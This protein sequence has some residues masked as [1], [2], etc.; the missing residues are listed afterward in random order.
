[1]IDYDKIAQAMYKAYADSLQSISLKWGL[2]RLVQKAA[3]IAAAKAA[4]KEPTLFWDEDEPERCHGSV[5]DV[6][7]TT[8]DNRC[9]EVGDEMIIEMAVRLPSLKV[10]ITATEDENGNTDLEWEEV[11]AAHQELKEVK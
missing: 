5:A 1:M 2:L 9:L 3:W 8:H 6:I 4:H 7:V 10:R 11:T